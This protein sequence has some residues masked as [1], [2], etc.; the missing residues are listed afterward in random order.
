MR[1]TENMRVLRL[2]DAVVQDEI[3]SIDGGVLV[4]RAAPYQEEWRVVSEREP[5]AREMRAMDLALK[6][7]RHTK[8]NA[9][10]F[11]DEKAVLG[12]GAG[13]MN[14]VESAEIAVKKARKPLA[15]S[16]VASDAFLPFPDTLEIAAAAGRRRSSS[17][18]ARSGS[19]GHR[20]GKPAQCSDDL[21][22]RAP[23][24]A[25]TTSPSFQAIS[26]RPG[27]AGA[28]RLRLQGWGGLFVGEWKWDTHLV[29][30]TVK[31]NLFILHPGNAR[32]CPMVGR[33]HTATRDGWCQTAS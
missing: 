13:Q 7:C 25:L 23:L 30:A 20:C 4:Q 1:V 15:G 24:P 31:G 17:R 19:G 5:D 29:G 21:Y 27:V 16:A 14:R 28:G 10:V 26:L 33:I 22:R 12:I 6:V 11:A 32:P 3:R 8:S 2:P 9:I 18:A